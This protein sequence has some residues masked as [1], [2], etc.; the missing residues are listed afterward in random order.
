MDPDD[1]GAAAV[2]FGL[3]VPITGPVVVA[4]GE[5]GRVWKV[6]TV[7]GQ[8]ALKEPL[9]HI[10]PPSSAEAAF[11]VEFQERMLSAGVPLPRPVRAPAGAAL[12]GRWRAHEWADLSPF[13]GPFDLLGAVMAR[14]H[15]NAPLTDAPSDPW[16]V[17]PVLE[18]TWRALL[19]RAALAAAPWAGRVG[20]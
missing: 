12:I 14:M 3:G 20:A 9:A 10:L 16:Y 2:A 15:A 4:R 18:G 11:N 7:Q 8:F 17:D 6:A 1:A 19:T 13:T 5:L